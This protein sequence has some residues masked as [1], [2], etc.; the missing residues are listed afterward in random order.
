[1][2]FD[3]IAKQSIAFQKTAFT[4]W[5]N[6]VATIQGQFVSAAEEMMSQTRL[7]MPVTARKT[8]INWANACQEGLKR[9]HSYVEI[10][11]SSIERLLV[12]ES[13]AGAARPLERLTEEKKGAPAQKTAQISK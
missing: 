4:H 12:Q 9:F 11:F 7:P 5:Y 10:G 13:T 3:Q 1:M 2:N 6:A 8:V